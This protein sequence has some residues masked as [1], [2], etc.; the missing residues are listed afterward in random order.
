MKGRLHSEIGNP[1]DSTQV[2]ICVI[3]T[4]LDLNF[5]FLLM[6][7]RMQLQKQQQFETERRIEV[8]LT[9]QVLASHPFPSERWYHGWSSEHLYLVSKQ[10]TTVKLSAKTTPLKQTSAVPFEPYLELKLLVPLWHSYEKFLFANR[11]WSKLV[12]L[13]HGLSC[14]NIRHLQK[15]LMGEQSFAVNK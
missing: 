13:N 10:K 1:T 9:A 4:E 6:V 3:F 11:S 15:R 7:L 8:C 12:V 5:S 2:M 14:F